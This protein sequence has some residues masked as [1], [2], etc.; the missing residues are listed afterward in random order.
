MWSARVFNF[1][2]TPRATLSNLLGIFSVPLSPNVR[3][4][5]QLGRARVV[6]KCTDRPMDLK[7][8]QL[9]QLL[10]EGGFDN[11][12]ERERRTHDVNHALAK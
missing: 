11:F 7:V 5:P 1:A 8:T 9:A 2:Q 12:S 4:G 10:L 6:R 3:P